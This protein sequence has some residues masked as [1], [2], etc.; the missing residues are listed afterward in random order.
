MPEVLHGPL[1]LHVER[2]NNV[3]LS[4]RNP[5]LAEIH[6]IRSQLYDPRRR[7]A[8]LEYARCNEQTALLEAVSKESVSVTRQVFID[9]QFSA[10]NQPLVPMFQR[11]VDEAR[12]MASKESIKYK[13]GSLKEGDNSFDVEIW[14]R[15]REL[16]EQVKLNEY[17]VSGEL[18]SHY[19]IVVS[20]FPEEMNPHTAHELGYFPEKRAGKVRIHDLNPQTGIKQTIEFFYTGSTL[21]KIKEIGNLLG[22]EGVFAHLKSPSYALEQ[23]IMVSKVRTG[24]WLDILRLLS[25][26]L[27]ENGAQDVARKSQVVLSEAQPLIDSLVQFDVEMALSLDKGEPRPAVLK[28][29]NLYLRKYPKESA[30][31][32]ERDRYLLYLGRDRFTNNVA[33]VLK[34]IAL[35]NTYTQ[36]AVLTDEPSVKDIA[37][38]KSYIRNHLS[39][40]DNPAIDGFLSG[41]AR[42]V[43]FSFCGMSIGG[44]QSAYGYM[45]ADY[46]R[47]MFGNE[48][49]FEC[50]SCHRVTYGPVGNR[51]PKCSITLEEWKEKIAEEKLDIETCE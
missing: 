44:A 30:V 36:V 25:P 26:V 40:Y 48:L 2:T 12:R 13:A 7:Q 39:I 43:A 3:S 17:A 50:P 16:D 31:L 29:I 22:L 33:A 15:E 38:L 49:V 6:D 10:F 1:R 14:R 41:G 19:M 37:H 21:E 45:P 11:G 8:A 34:K 5:L 23:T 24:G 27:Y 28:M 9:G 51:C 32:S 20:P 18:N 35:I 42:S 47:A 46:L 4:K